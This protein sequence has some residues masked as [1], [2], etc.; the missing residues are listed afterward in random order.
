MWCFGITCLA[1]PRSI[2]TASVVTTSLISV[3]IA[4]SASGQA[5]VWQQQPVS[6]PIP[7]FLQSMTFDSLRGV[8]VLYGGSL[9]ANETWEFNGTAWSLRSTWGPQNVSELGMAYHTPTAKTVIFGGRIGNELTDQTWEWNGSTWTR[10]WSIGP[11][12]RHGHAMV[13][14][15]AQGNIVLFGG[16][17]DLGTTYSN[18]TWTWNGDLWAMVPVTGPSP[19]FF[20]AMAYDS[21][22]A[23]TVLFGGNRTTNLRDTWEWDGTAWTQRSDTGPSARYGHTMSFDPN[24][25]VTLLFGGDVGGDQTWEWNGS[26]WTQVLIA[27]PSTR[28]LHSMTFDASRNVA[29]I[30]GGFGSTGVLGDTWQLCT[31]P[32]VTE[33]PQSQYG[34]L[35]GQ[36]IFTV[37]AS[38]SGPFSYQWRRSDLAI[39]IVGATQATLTLDPVFE[40][41]MGWYECI[42]TNSCGTIASTPASLSLCA[43]DFN[44]DCGIDFF[45]YLDFV[46][47]F[48]SSDMRADFNRDGTI[49]FFDYLDFVDVFGDGC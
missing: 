3:F 43:A 42:V 13:Y 7:R 8:N 37:S 18:E 28:S 12:A 38:G 49:D 39:D 20:H 23:K 17:T 15:A 32:L 40:T 46:S 27:G 24:R 41:D 14:D 33:Q 21:A 44:S 2:V 34:C 9:G 31:T 6:G 10:R 48:S 36:A 22:R 16:Q 4:Q 5:I 47:S 1:P 35:G 25:N 19:R 29:V 26:F 45:D 30:F 11:S